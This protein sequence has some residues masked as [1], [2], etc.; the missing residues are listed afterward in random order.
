MWNTCSMRCRISQ[1]SA[2]SMS[3]PTLIQSTKHSGRIQY[4]KPSPLVKFQCPSTSCWI[5]FPA[6]KELWH[7]KFVLGVQFLFWRFFFTWKPQVLTR[8]Y[9][10]DR[11]YGQQTLSKTG[12]LT[13]ERTSTINDTTLLYVEGVHMFNGL[14][15]E[16]VDQ[17]LEENLKIIPQI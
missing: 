17:Y 13:E 16:E 3:R 9:S 14:A 8:F 2:T 6:S 12:S 10:D 15:D 11:G 7:L 4:G 1:V 5:S